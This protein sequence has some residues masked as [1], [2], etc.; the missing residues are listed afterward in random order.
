M[1]A[2]Q[3]VLSTLILSMFSYNAHISAFW[4]NDACGN[5]CGTNSGGWVFFGEYLYWEAVQDQMQYAAIIPD[6]IEPIITAIEAGPPFDISAKLA[7]IDP[8]FNY[9]SGFRIGIGYEVPCSNWDV[10]LAWVRLHEGGNVSSV[11][12]IANGIIPLTVPLSSVFGFIDRDPDEFGFA[13]KARSRWNFAFDTLDLQLGG[14]FPCLNCLVVRPFIGLKAATINQTQYIDYIGLTLTGL[15]IIVQNKKK[16]N[17]QGIGPSFG[18]D[19]SW[20][21][22]PH[23]NLTSGFSGALLYSNF[24]VN[25]APIA[26]Q[27]P[28]LI[29]VSLDNT[30]YKRVRPMVSTRIG[31]DWDTCLC[32]RFQVLIGVAYEFQY[33]WNQWQTPPSVESSIL[34]GGASPQGD[35]MLQGLTVKAVVPF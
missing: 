30:K 7:I 31:I 9:N 27:A 20:E 25:E 1:K 29:Q 17:F 8:S 35:L 28:T 22:Y 10:Q 16:N 23:L 11:S 15:P 19:S 3:I 32:D 2:F 33:W 24:Y 21:F 26:V 14:T 12:S 6:G 18:I 34:N 4:E 13:S 5:E